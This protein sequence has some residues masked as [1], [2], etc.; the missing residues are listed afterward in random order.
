MA[1]PLHDTAKRMENRRYHFYRHAN[2]SRRANPAT[3]SRRDAERTKARHAN[4][5]QRSG[6]TPLNYSQSRKTEQTRAQIARSLTN[7]RN[8]FPAL[9]CIAG[10][11]PCRS[12]GFNRTTKCGHNLAARRTCSHPQATATQPR[13]MRGVPQKR[14]GH[15]RG[16]GA[17]C[18]KVGGSQPGNVLSSNPNDVQAGQ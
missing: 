3:T 12:T 2:E 13:R 7:R 10:V 5:E 17:P 15:F 8:P 16:S 4:T 18:R 14:W 11:P 9:H 6:A 1:K